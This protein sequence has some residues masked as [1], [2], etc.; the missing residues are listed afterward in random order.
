MALNPILTGQINY[1]LRGGPLEMALQ[2]LRASGQVE[3]GYT[4]RPYPKML[5]L[6]KGVQKIQ[7]RTTTCDKEVVHWVDERE[8]FDEIV[9]AS[10]EEEERV[11]A[12]GRTSDQLEEERL[13]LLHRCR[14]AGIG[15]DPG[16]TSVRLRRELGDKLDEP[17]VVGDRMASLEA[18][19]AYERK[20]AAMEEEIAV[21]RA[22]KVEG[23]EAE[24]MRA[25]LA[26]LGVKADGRWSIAKLREE[27]NRH[28][29]PNGV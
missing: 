14:A 9:V 7:R 24:E 13:G 16:W 25:Q 5:R 21:L 22:R 26:D 2:Q 12:G 15:A 10:E 29:S 27:L 11:L 4:Y 19:L 17:L 8:V 18:E 20:I 23:S 28:T 6:S 3:D 1:M